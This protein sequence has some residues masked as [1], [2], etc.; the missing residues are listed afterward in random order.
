MSDRSLDAPPTVE[1]EPPRLSM[2]IPCWNAATTIEWSL[3][4]VLGEHGPPFE[5]IVIDDASTD[6]TADIVQ[7]IAE[8]DPR[9]V[10]LRLPENVG[11][12]AARNR[13]LDVVRGEWVAF[14]D[15]D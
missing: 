11:V 1:S 13:G 10:L 2:L 9:V 7:A 14:H 6:G 15:A 12:S 8:H 3:A 5:C 4:S